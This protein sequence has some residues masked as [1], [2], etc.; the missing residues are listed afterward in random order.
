MSKLEAFFST[1]YKSRKVSAFDFHIHKD[2]ETRIKRTKRCSR[3]NA[4][5]ETWHDKTG[6]VIMLTARDCL[7]FSD[8]DEAVI[9]VICEHEHL[10]PM[11]AIEKGAFLMEQAWGAAAI[12]HMIVDQ[13]EVTHDMALYK[14]HMKFAREHHCDDTDREAKG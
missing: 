4:P 14:L 13:Y 9:Q 12:D 2:I 7:D 5:D 8:L 1:L 11:L 10:S 3:V 6:R